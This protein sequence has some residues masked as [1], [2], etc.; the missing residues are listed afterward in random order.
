[1]FLST[2]RRIRVLY[3][4]LLLILASSL[5]NLITCPHNKFSQHF[6][7]RQAHLSTHIHQLIKPN[8]SENNFSIIL[9]NLKLPCKHYNKWVNSFLYWR[10]RRAHFSTRGPRPRGRRSRFARRMFA[11]PDS[12]CRRVDE[13]ELELDLELDPVS[14]KTNLRT[15]SHSQRR[16][17][18]VKM[19]ITRNDST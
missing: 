14:R 15:R 12:D 9:D 11:L 19:M 2:L 7:I 6:F 3:F 16:M 1:L 18:F 4:T 17:R 8:Y 13:S 5:I 10:C